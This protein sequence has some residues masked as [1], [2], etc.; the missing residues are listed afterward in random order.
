MP[1]AVVKTIARANFL[2][3]KYSI[4]VSTLLDRDNTRAGRLP[5]TAICESA[6]QQTV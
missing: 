3:I 5:S 4:A 2:T 6:S 1:A